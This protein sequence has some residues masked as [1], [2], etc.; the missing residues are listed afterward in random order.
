MTFEGLDEKGGGGISKGGSIYLVLTIVM[1]NL[2][3]VFVGSSYY[4]F[5]FFSLACVC[6]NVCVGVSE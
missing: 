5:P 4:F 1:I 2:T 3:A 6:V